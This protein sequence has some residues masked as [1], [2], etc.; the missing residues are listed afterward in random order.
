MLL[1]LK[2]LFTAS[3]DREH[4]SLRGASAMKPVVHLSRLLLVCILLTPF[5][6]VFPADPGNTV[7]TETL[8]AKI[9][10]V[11]ASTSL[12]V[13]T[14]TQLTELYRKAL[15]DLERTR[16]SQA[17][18]ESYQQARRTAPDET[19]AI[20]ARIQKTRAISAADELNITDATPLA[21]LEQLL[22][23]EKA[24]YAAV[25][26][27]LA[28]QQ[29]QLMTEK[30]RPGSVREEITRATQRKEAIAAELRLT[31]PADQIVEITEAR[32]LV[33]QNEDRSLDTELHMLD[34]ELLSQS[35]RVEL[36]K[37]QTDQS[38]LSLERI[39]TLI[40]LLE[41]KLTAKRLEEAQHAQTQAVE[42]QR[43]A[44]G[45]NPL[46][47]ALASQNAALSNE[48]A[49]MAIDFERVTDET[50]AANRD[51]QRYADALHSA[52]Q[53]LEVA[54]LSQALGQVLLEQ[55]RT[56]PNVQLLQGKANVLERQIADASL[57][58]ILHEEELHSLRDTDDYVD[59]LVAK[60]DKEEADSL[61][62]ELKRLVASRLQ[63]LEKAVD[64]HR[65]L[66]DALGE[67]AF[68]QRR[69]VE[70][71]RVYDRFLDERLLWIR[72]SP[73]PSLPMLLEMPDQ[74]V[75]L[76][77]PGHWE[78][79]VR[80]LA[81]EFRHSPILT[82]G[83][84]VFGLLLWHAR[85]MRRAL[86]ETG[87]PVGKVSSDSF[88][89]TVKALGLT[90]GLAAPWPLLLAVTGWSLAQAPAT[91]AFPGAVARGL[92]WESNALFYLLAFRALCCTGGL[93]EAH[94][95]WPQPSLRI[96][97]RST[98][99]LML[100]FLPASFAGL[101]VIYSESPSLGGGLGRLALVV[102]LLLLGLFSYRLLDP[103]HGPLTVHMRAHPKSLF[104]RL[105]RL[106]VAVAVAVPLG[107]AGLA[108]AGYVYTA[109]TLTKSLI[110]T[111][112]LVLVLVVAHRL[113]IRWLLV[114]QRR[115]A[116]RA[117]VDKREA[118]RV[119]AENAESASTKRADEIFEV[120]YQTPDLSTLREDS[121]KL[122]TAAMY[123]IGV[124]GI[125]LI[126]SAV[127]PAFGI[128]DEIVLWNH[129]SVVDGEEKLLP[130]TLADAG[131]SMLIAVV[132]VVATQ[133]FPALLEIGLLQRLNM[134][135][136]ARYTATTLAR[137]TIAAVGTVAAFATLGASWSQIQ[138]LIAAL[139]VG[140]GFGLQEI[141]ANFISGIIIL[142]ERP[143]RIGDTVTVGET[144]G[145][146]TRI[147]I[148]ATTIR[149]WDGLELLV[150]NKEFITSRLLN[151]TLSDP[152][153][154]I[155]I[156]V[157]L[158]Y[159]GDVQQAMALM[160]EAAAENPEVLA[161][162]RPNV[163]FD[164]FGDNALS[165]KLRCFVGSM[166]NRIRTISELHQAINSKFNAA[167]LVVAFPQQDV[168]LDTSRPLDIRIRRDDGESP[169]SG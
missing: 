53:K 105:R 111:L 19:R 150:P 62:P 83:F 47:G 91:S 18:A 1:T 59:K 96:L 119:A 108:V 52:Q 142:F 114:S 156:P 57:R 84:L 5:S 110:D 34:Q 3:D 55:R 140:I 66:L 138:W 90:I 56:L 35:V 128:L 14:K 48:L 69:L 133:R 164:K 28:G 33:L 168:H 134:T 159:G 144:I 36:L 127:L 58:Q 73:A 106:W 40:A 49:A 118:A 70:N 26:A 7:T 42:A 44:A 74:A 155:T 13:A 15:T 113:T 54:S 107:L 80:I 76:F 94:F 139:G 27:K 166:E 157:G 78:E 100:T 67:L 30:E 146:V 124:V 45:K 31:P 147:Q 93:A 6:Q 165:L 116:Y 161:D 82:I 115:L 152:T 154:R 20:R 137:Y 92:S 126:W 51:A 103:V 64:M 4:E 132:M 79:V 25:E 120:E 22:L 85:K 123:I 101:I 46:L 17:T 160:L 61:R 99:R 29:K 71:T 8:Q 11:E 43:E 153:S 37:A 77:N 136:S 81:A 117:A 39:G 169:L 60:L 145:T 2:A 63:L 141:V 24:N 21:D 41:D 23:K 75:Q 102:V 158:A 97:R 125:W 32:K 149:D 95:R 65:T 122:L 86:R 16:S 9:A 121:R 109:G 112:W 50:S 163:I 135:A 131:L 162:P 12:D 68:E 104:T 88:V 167:G 72:S 148:R 130:I 89:E 10:E 87:K 143:V 38:S 129:M 98:N 151:W